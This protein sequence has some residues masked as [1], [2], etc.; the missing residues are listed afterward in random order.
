MCIRG[1]CFAVACARGL[2]LHKDYHPYLLSETAAYRERPQMAPQRTTTLDF[3]DCILNPT[4]PSGPQD[5]P[6]QPPEAS[7]AKRRSGR[8]SGQELKVKVK[9]C[10]RHLRSPLFSS[11]S[12]AKRD[13]GR[14]VVTYRHLSPH[15]TLA[16]RHL[17]PLRHREIG[18]LLPGGG[19]Q[20]KNTPPPRG[21]NFLLGGSDP[22]P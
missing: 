22:P 20:S 9:A 8:G 4:L 13:K 14:H 16:Y 17:P 1:E 19:R 18:P 21:V 5:S 10:R 11:S 6:E 15:H 3:I 2:P 12:K 7:K